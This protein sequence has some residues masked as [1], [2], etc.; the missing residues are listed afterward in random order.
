MLVSGHTTQGRGGPNCNRT[1][2]WKRTPQ[3][4]DTIKTFV[5]C[6]SS[7]QVT[8]KALSS[9]AW[10]KIFHTA[11]LTHSFSKQTYRPHL[12]KP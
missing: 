3:H 4:D 5:D 7:S 10:V 9:K 8:D 6:H 2:L 12:K 1:A 11:I